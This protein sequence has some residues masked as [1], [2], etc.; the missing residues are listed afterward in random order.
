MINCRGFTGEGRSSFFDK[1]MAFS[2]RISKLTTVGVPPQIP[3]GDFTFQL[4]TFELDL[5]VLILRG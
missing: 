2:K 1:G 5:T 3:A 4:E